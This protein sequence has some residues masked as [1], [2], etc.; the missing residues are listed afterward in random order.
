MRQVVREG[1]REGVL[2]RR[3]DAIG[4]FAVHVEDRAAQTFKVV[5]TFRGLP[6]ATL[7]KA[8]LV[9][10]LE[11]AAVVR[12]DGETAAVV[13]TVYDME[14]NRPVWTDAE[15]PDDS[16]YEYPKYL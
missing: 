3:I 8:M 9:A 16:T 10:M 5:D 14:E 4:V 11:I 13:A 6:I 1:V 2:V 15:L 12:E 7:G